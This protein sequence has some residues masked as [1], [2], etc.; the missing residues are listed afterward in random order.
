MIYQQPIADAITQEKETTA[1]VLLSGLSF[2]SL[3]AAIT[4]TVVDAAEAA[5]VFSITTTMAADADAVI[6]SGC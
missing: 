1:V 2:Y 4:T 6:G 5:S 3:S